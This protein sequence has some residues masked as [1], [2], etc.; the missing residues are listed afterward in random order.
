MN[1]CATL[2][3]THVHART[4]TKIRSHTHSLTHTQGEEEHRM[5]SH[6]DGRAQENDLIAMRKRYVD[7]HAFYSMK[8]CDVFVLSLDE[9]A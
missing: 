3:R 4:Q 1:C 8:N 7:E 5:R 6:F 9:H 2:A